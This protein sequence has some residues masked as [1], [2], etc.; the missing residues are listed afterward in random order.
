MVRKTY[1]DEEGSSDEDVDVF[2]PNMNRA[3]SR[4]EG[5]EEG[6]EDDYLDEFNDSLNR[7]SIT[8]KDSVLKNKFGRNSRTPMQMPSKL[9]PSMSPESL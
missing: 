4:D 1:E 3:A 8:P 6:F 7:M 9:K 5:V 2:Y